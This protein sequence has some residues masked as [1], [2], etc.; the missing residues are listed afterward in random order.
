[1]MIAVDDRVYIGV[2]EDRRVEK[3][4]NWIPVVVWGVQAEK[5]SQY[6]QKGSK[7][8]V[9]GKLS[10]RSY[11]DKEGVT[12]NTFEIVAENIEFLGNIRSPDR[13]TDVTTEVSEETDTTEVQL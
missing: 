6:L 5:C 11:K 1:M 10:T 13:A 3:R 2:G 9:E 8:L 7:I 12:R 4:T